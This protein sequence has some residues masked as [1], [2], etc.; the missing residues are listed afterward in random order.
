MRCC[1]QEVEEGGCFGCEVWA[2]GG[3]EAGHFCGGGGGVGGESVGRVLCRVVV[4]RCACFWWFEGG[5]WF[6]LVRRVRWCVG[7][8]VV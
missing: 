2:V 7:W 5:G 6:G 4:C 1:V 8:R 3:E